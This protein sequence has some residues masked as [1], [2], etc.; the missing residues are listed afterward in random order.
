M[1]RNFMYLVVVASVSAYADKMTLAAPTFFADTGH[2]Y[3]LVH[4]PS[5]I[6][7]SDA[8]EAAD[9]RRYGCL[10]A[11]LVTI[12]SAAESVFVESNFLIYD[13][14]SWIGGFQPPGSAEPDGGWT[15]ITGEPWQFTNWNKSGPEPN[16]SGGNE[17]V[18]ELE[19]GRY[20][21]G[22]NDAMETAVRFHYI[23]EYDEVI[24][25]PGAFILGT[26]GVGFVGWLRRRRTL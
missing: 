22:W 13:G 25:A 20:G 3:E 4:V 17:N 15:W 12:T 8:R 26:I 19:P 16:N 21:G 14:A 9:A 7:W 6:N 23:A 18:L 5:G 24:P 11:H 2:Y 1:K 10:S